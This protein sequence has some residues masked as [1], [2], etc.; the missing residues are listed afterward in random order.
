[1]GNNLKKLVLLHSN[2][3]HA[4]FMSTKNNDVDEGGMAL[5]SGYVQKVREEEENVIYVIAGDMFNG[6]VLDSEYLGLGTLNMINCIRPDVVCVGNHELDYGLTHTLFIEKCAAF[7]IVNSNL[8]IRYIAKPLYTPYTFIEKGGLKILFTGIITDQIAQNLKKDTFAGNLIDIIDPASAVKNVLN[9]VKDEHADLNILLTHIGIEE[10]KK[11][12]QKIGDTTDVD[13]II[14]GHSHTVLEKPEIVNNIVI[15]Q[16]GIGTHQIGRFDIY[17]D[18]DTKEIDHFDWHIVPI[19]SET[20]PEFEE[21][22]EYI[23]D[24]KNETDEK[25][26]KVICTFDRTLENGARNRQTELGNFVADIFKDALDVDVYLLSSGSFRGKELGPVVTYEEL[27]NI[28][29]YSSPIYKLSVTG[30]QLMDMLLFAFSKVDLNDP[31]SSEPQLSEGFKIVYNTK[32][33][34]FDSF[35]F[36]GKEIDEDKLYTLGIGKFMC[37]GFENYFGIK[38]E[39]VEKNGKPQKICHDDQQALYEYLESNKDFFITK[40]NRLS[41]I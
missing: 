6:S 41:I 35:L 14:G 28:F 20:S 29:P 23:Q 5:L 1:M 9:E 18:E 26:Q 32:E 33:K 24:L 8:Y 15:T 37:V 40:P 27:I 22:S 30:K 12:A 31:E 16:A 34:C 36:K 4:D 2:D 21:M 13:L 7:P 17:Y 38:I 3:I 11:L 19:N 10:D 39:E 25:Y